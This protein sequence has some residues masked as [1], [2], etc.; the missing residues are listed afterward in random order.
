MGMGALD[1]T[2][3]EVL[4]SV[5]IG[6][7]VD[8]QKP[9]S[10]PAHPVIRGTL[11]LARARIRGK[12]DLAG[13]EIRPGNGHAAVE[14][15]AVR[16]G[17]SVF[18][19]RYA[20]N[21]E[22][23][24]PYGPVH[25]TG[26]RVRQDVYLCEGLFSK[27]VGDPS[28]P[29]VSFSRAVI[30]GLLQVDGCRHRAT[31][32]AAADHS[33][34]F[35]PAEIHEVCRFDGALDLTHA[36]AGVLRDDFTTTD[37]GR[38]RTREEKGKCLVDDIRLD[39]FVFDALD[40]SCDRSAAARL[41]FLERM[42]KKYFSVQPYEHIAKLLDQAGQDE[43]AKEVLIEESRRDFEESTSWL[44]RQ[45]GHVLWALLGYGHRKFKPLWYLAY[46]VVVGWIVFGLGDRCALLGPVGED[47]L[48]S[49]SWLARDTLSRAMSLDEQRSLGLPPGFPP[50]SPLMYSLD[51]AL[52]IIDL[53]Q[54]AYWIPD[55]ARG[56]VISH[57][58]WFG[59]LTTAR[60]LRWYM[61]AHI[62]LGW[63][64]TTFFIVGLTG[65]VKGGKSENVTA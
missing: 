47:V 29:A 43:D 42:P 64:F 48:V 12:L 5:W 63:T 36:R 26:A 20:I 37:H 30:H 25:F 39:G 23:V 49:Q 62:L 54:E 11:V 44:R 22:P 60:V 41:A 31:A 57:D 19:N 17:G 46:L 9:G 35:G 21:H 33:E 14:A 10:S 13:L 56:R 1:L 24:R 59:D 32:D 15:D 16:V 3:A 2:D 55:P 6:S 65:L 34:L 7:W 4:G 52:P 50:L 27:G 18:L 51:L 28:S 40:P 45:W 8:P 61:W 38:R 53:R 58:T